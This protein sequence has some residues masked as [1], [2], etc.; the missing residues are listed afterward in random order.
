MDNTIQDEVPA[1]EVALANHCCRVLK[2]I[3]ENAA[4]RLE[5]PGNGIFMRFRK[6]DQCASVIYSEND[7]LTE[8]LSAAFDK[9]VKENEGY[10]PPLIKVKKPAENIDTGGN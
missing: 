7:S 2:I 5:L 3:N 4:E 10:T 9:W 6:P 8:A 1:D